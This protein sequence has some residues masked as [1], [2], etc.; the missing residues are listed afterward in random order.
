M[1]IPMEYKMST[2]ESIQESVKD[3]SIPMSAN[4]GACCGGSDQIIVVHEGEEIRDNVQEF[5][6]DRAR[7]SSSCCGDASQNLLYE[8]DLL[9]DLPDDVVNFTLGCGDPITLA[10]LQP[11]EVV[12][13]LGSGGGL[14][15][16]L[17]AKQV[18]EDGYVI[19]IDMTPEMLERATA[20]AQRMGIENVEFRQGYLE[21]MPVDNDS[22]DV[23]I[24][25]CV[26]NLSPDKPK[27]FAEMFRT[28]KPGG[29][30]SVSDIVTSGE[31]PEAIRKDMLAWG[32]CIAGALEMDE[33]I[34]GLEQV[35][36]EDVSLVAKTGEGELLE[37]IP[38]NSLFSASITARKPISPD[39]T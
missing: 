10:Q 37:G 6:A 5:Y 22:V 14:D 33:Y 34:Q 3:K 30:V 27:V 11:G 29:R 17:A 15:C 16:F 2:T 32:A 4:E 24:S 38:E 1:K 26:I 13:D 20:A 7:N 19:G 21:D 18:G 31:L 23:V 8:S 39:Y 9:S 12:L 25:N 35:G 36:F 28:L